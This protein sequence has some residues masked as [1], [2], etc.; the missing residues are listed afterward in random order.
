[1]AKLCFKQLKVI[2]DVLFYISSVAM[3]LVFKDKDAVILLLLLVKQISFCRFRRKDWAGFAPY[4][5][6]LNVF[7]LEKCIFRIKFLAHL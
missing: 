2:L 7:T 6:L 1:M 3:Q 5:E 4:L